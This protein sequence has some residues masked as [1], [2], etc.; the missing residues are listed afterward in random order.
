MRVE[1]QID[2]QSLDRRRVMADLVIARRLRPAQFEPVER[3][4]PASGAQS[5]RR[6]ASLPAST[7]ITGSW[8]N[9][10]WSIRSS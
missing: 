10:S 1:E 6:A 3:D 2:Q 4:L 7:A 8:R 5:A 9:W